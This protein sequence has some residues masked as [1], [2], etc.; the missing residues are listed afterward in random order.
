MKILC[1]GDSITYGAWDSRG[2]WVARLRERLDR[3]CID[4]DLSTFV[5]TY[6]LGIDSDTTED[7]LARIQG[8]LAALR[9]E[10][11]DVVIVSLGT[12]DSV[13]FREEQ[14]FW[15]APEAYEANLLRIVARARQ[16]CDHVVVLGICP[17]D[18]AKTRPY[19]SQPNLESRNDDLRAYEA[20]AARVAAA[21]GAVFV[22]VFERF[23]AAGAPD[24]LF[25][26]GLHPG[27][28]GHALLA[29]LVEPVVT[30]WVTEPPE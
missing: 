27:D 26:D 4:T 21:G 5:L 22:P 29:A 11:H 6:N 10:R 9:P 30:P 18:E 2:G 17:V 14:R 19:R 13:W 3:I 28:E 23:A 25:A 8:A 15:V 24:L 12:N 16:R 1:F 20:A 7:V